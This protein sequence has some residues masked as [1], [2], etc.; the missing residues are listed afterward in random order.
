[1]IKRRALLPKVAKMLDRPFEVKLA[2]T[3][4]IIDH[5][6]EEFGKPGE[7]EMVVA[8][9]GGKDSTLLLWLML[10]KIPGIAVIFENTGV[11]APETIAFIREITR[12]WKLTLYETHPYKK[13][14]W[15]CV[16]EY[17]YPRG[18][19][20]GRK[21]KK[22]DRCCYY[23]KE[24]PFQLAI[25]E[26]PEWKAVLLGTL[27]EENRQRQIKAATLGTC[28]HA[29]KENICKV[30]PLL[31]W[32]EAEIWEYTRANDIPINPL[33]AKGMKR[34]GC[35]PCTAYT[36]WKESLQ[37]VNPRMYRKIM[38]DQGQ[39]LLLKGD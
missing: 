2:E 18:K 38:K 39:E 36:S 33:Y 15:D 17:G 19:G 25:R 10:Q 26:H 34:C 7:E 37:K 32:T 24:R 20:S 35:L 29:K 31:W 13:N 9:S 23:L 16:R 11:E 1:M 5:H 14:F 4:H 12:A 27:A 28:Y 21:G 30:F 6:I 22:T 3:W 8:W